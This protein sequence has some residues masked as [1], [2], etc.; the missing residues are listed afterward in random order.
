M[1]EGN[2]AML[3]IFSTVTN[4]GCQKLLLTKLNYEVY[5]WQIC[6]DLKVIAIILGI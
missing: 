4:K 5:Q 1:I 2:F 6:G 3:V